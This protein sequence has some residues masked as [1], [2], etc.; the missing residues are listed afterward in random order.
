[1]KYYPYQK[2]SNYYNQIKP[3]LFN[4]I[5]LFITGVVSLTITSQISFHFSPSDI[6]YYEQTLS[7]AAILTTICI[8]GFDSSAFLEE[9][10]N[11]SNEH[12]IRNETDKIKYEGDLVKMRS[13]A[14]FLNIIS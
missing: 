10:K 9:I 12:Q 4:Y 8:W 14:L 1:M 7:I 11:K 13:F 5:T 2:I 3:L 6:N